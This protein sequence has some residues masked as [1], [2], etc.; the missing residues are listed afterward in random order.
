MPRPHVDDPFLLDAA[1]GCKGL[2][3]GIGEW[4]GEIERELFGLVD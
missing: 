3:D 2:G 1:K 4:I